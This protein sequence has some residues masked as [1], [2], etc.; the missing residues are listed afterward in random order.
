M[1]SLPGLRVGGAEGRSWYLWLF[2]FLLGVAMSVAGCSYNSAAAPAPA[3]E[4][5]N[6]FGHPTR[7]QDFHGR[8][9]V[10]TFLYSHCPDTCPLYLSNIA[11]ALDATKEAGGEPPTVAVITVDPD[12][13]TV[14]RL[15]EFSSG[16]PSDWL[17]LTGTYQ[18]LARVW[19][20]YGIYVQK[21][22]QENS[23]EVHHGYSVLHNQKALVIDR[24]GRLAGELTGTWSSE[25]LVTSLRAVQQQ[26]GASLI[27]P[28]TL[29]SGLLRSCGEFAVAHPGLFLGLV[30]TLMLPGL[31]LP[32]YLLRTFLGAHRSQADQL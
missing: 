14:Q 24:E 1:S 15:R 28:T 4:L 26:Q 6:Q 9:V 19:A 10:L 30:I 5:S 17:F 16:W 13:D 7:L 11:K 27:K 20:S 32:I 22:P 25:T 29:F 8:P 3:L 31:V 21:Q 23:S 12:R 18:Q 2:G